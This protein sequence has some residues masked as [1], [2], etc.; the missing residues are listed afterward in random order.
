MFSELPRLGWLFYLLVISSFIHQSYSTQLKLS[1]SGSTLPVL[2]L[3]NDSLHVKED[4]TA[5]EG[6]ISLVELFNLITTLQ[7]R[8]DQLNVTSPPAN[9]SS[10]V[11]L[12]QSQIDQLN[13]TMAFQRNLINQLNTTIINQ[14]ATI[15]TLNT[16][17]IA[18]TTSV[19]QRSKGA[20]LYPIPKLP[21]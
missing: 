18:L 19:N 10:L 1:Q 16:S 6:Q 13:T 12:L 14:Q 9:D 21:P 17:L 20:S 8:V 2:R 3:S 7:A 4:I 5:R 15:N 11:S